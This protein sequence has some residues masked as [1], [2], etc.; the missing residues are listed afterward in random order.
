MIECL[1]VVLLSNQGESYMAGKQHDGLFLFSSP[2]LLRDVDYPNRIYG[3]SAEFGGAVYLKGTNDKG[4]ASMELTDGSTICRNEA[5]EAGAGVYLEEGTTL[6]LSGS[7]DFGGNVIPGIG[8][9]ITGSLINK[10]NGGIS[11]DKARQD[12]YIVETGAESSTDTKYTPASIIIT[13]D[14]TSGDGSIWVWAEN[15]YR[16]KQ[17]MPFAKM[18]D[19]VLFAETPTGA[20]LDAAH[21]KAFRNAQ[22]DEL[23]EN[24]T[25]TYLYGTIEGEVTDKGIIYWT[26][27]SGSR[28]VILRKVDD[29]YSSLSGKTF[30]VYK[31]LSTSPYIVKNGNT[32]T[33][34]GGGTNSD[35]TVTVDP[36]KSLDSGVFWIGN[37]P[38]GWYIIEETDA[39]TPRFF[40]L[41]V[42]ESGTYGMPYEEGTVKGGYTDRTAAQNA[43]KTK[44]D[45]VKLAEK[46]GS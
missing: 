32:R 31:G 39:T 11:Y 21:L 17:L 25:D 16:Y 27:V 36:M 23:T 30:I 1:P 43:G 26:G 45:A 3:C 28:K 41:V 13:G 14:I 12:I 19:G 42:S 35:T 46:S 18:A 9:F 7:P 15:Q 29:K 6:K 5:T 38:Y 33:Q 44:Y 37:L 10:Q 8:N 40:W 22:D 4:G 24:G 2:L 20:Q 34:L